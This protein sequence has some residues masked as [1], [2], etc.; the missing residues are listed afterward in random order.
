MSE[1][2]EVRSLYW[3]NEEAALS[4]TRVT[5]SNF[6]PSPANL[7]TPK[8]KIIQISAAD[9]NTVYLLYDDGTVAR[10]IHGKPPQFVSTDYPL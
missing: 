6:N 7:D 1:S 8:P 10:K 9:V 3:T 4:Q 5:G 2:L